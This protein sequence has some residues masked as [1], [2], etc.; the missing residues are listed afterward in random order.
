MAAK[1]KKAVYEIEVE[2]KKCQLSEIS[3]STLEVAL[4]LIM[5]TTGQ[6]QYIRAGEVILL[7]CWVSGD[8][9]IKNDESLLIAASMKAYEL[10]ELKEATLKK[11]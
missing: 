8:D 5:Q 9:E 6:P 10:I 7:N 11:I 4:G 2:G 1:K 3:R